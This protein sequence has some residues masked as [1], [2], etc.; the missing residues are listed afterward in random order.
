MLRIIGMEE[1]ETGGRRAFAR[2]LE[3]R[4]LRFAVMVIRLSGRLP[5]SPEGRV[6]RNQLARSGT[7]PGANYREAN[8]SRSKADFKSKIRICES[9]LSET[10]YWLELIGES[11]WLTEAH[12]KSVNDECGELLALFS[13]IARSCK[14]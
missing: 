10:L 3:Q 6:V 14:L 13:S 4:T 7:S 5:N 1:N 8:R 2:E 12:L 9:E 11:G